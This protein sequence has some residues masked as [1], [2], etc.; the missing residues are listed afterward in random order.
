MGFKG[1]LRRIACLWGAGLISLG[2]GN[3]VSRAEVQPR[4]NES[5]SE[6]AQ[7]A[8]FCEEMRA[9]IRALKWNVDPCPSDIQWKIGGYSVEGR[10]LIHAD[11]GNSESPNTTLILSMVHGDEVTPLYLGLELLSWV[12]ENSKSLGDH[13]LVIAPMV[14]PDSFFKK[15]RSRV[16]ARGVDVNRNFPTRDWDARAK[17]A[18]KERFKSNP[19][20][21]PGHVP[22]SE[23]ETRFQRELI[24]RVRPL[25]IL[26][27]HAPLNFMDYDGPTHLSLAQFPK[28]YV[29]ECLKLR[30]SLKATSGGFFP[31]SLGNYAGQ[32]LG[33][34]TLT[35]EL[36]SADPAKARI[37]W[38]RFRS[39]IKTMIEY[40]MPDVALRAMNDVKL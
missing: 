24:A 39:G 32:E 29:Q 5:A 35:L 38:E 25:K 1:N 15:P 30:K 4:E 10:P 6:T 8:V 7:I 19:R 14:N 23:P 21:F 31:G 18:W 37:Y 11:L 17:K 9:S 34:P 27:V 40:R 3:S 12:R 2:L 36:P 22:D 16:N 28:D 26:S 13:R 33:I 20:R